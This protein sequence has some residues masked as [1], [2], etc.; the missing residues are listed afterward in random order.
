MKVRRK[1]SVRLYW[2]YHDPTSRTEVLLK[3]TDEARVIVKDRSPEY[4]IT[5]A[6]TVT[7]SSEQE[8]QT[9]SGCW[10]G[11]V[12]KQRRMGGDW[13]GRARETE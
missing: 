4:T 7:E 5:P 13:R 8:D 10:S 6:R 12:K 1:G 2:S 11:K 3:Q 9:G